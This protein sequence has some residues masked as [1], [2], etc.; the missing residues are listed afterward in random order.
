MV[1]RFLGVIDWDGGRDGT[2]THVSQEVTLISVKYLR[3]SGA[4]ILWQNK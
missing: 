4:Y 2:D 1:Q 3:S